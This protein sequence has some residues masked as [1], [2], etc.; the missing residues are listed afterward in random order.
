MRRIADSTPI[1]PLVI[2]DCVVGEVENYLRRDLPEREA[3]VTQLAETADQLYKHSPRWHRRIKGNLGRDYLYSFM[4]HWL[5]AMLK[6]F[7]PPFSHV[8]QTFWSGEQLPLAPRSGRHDSP[9]RRNAVKKPSDKWQRFNI[10]RSNGSVSIV[11]VNVKT[12]RLDHTVSSVLEG[13]EPPDMTRCYHAL[14]C[15]SSRKVGERSGMLNDAIDA[16]HNRP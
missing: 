8:P 2:A 5:S 7:W 13:F 15:A 3:F 11:E 16:L 12:G 9:K 14:Q 4:R 6:D 1:L 10:M